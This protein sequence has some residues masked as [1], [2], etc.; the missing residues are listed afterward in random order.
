MN[1]NFLNEKFRFQF[2]KIINLVGWGFPIVF[3][4][5]IL[6]RKKCPFIYSQDSDYMVGV[7]LPLLNTPEKNN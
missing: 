4:L 5:S 2:F 3:I 7:A 1:S 6:S